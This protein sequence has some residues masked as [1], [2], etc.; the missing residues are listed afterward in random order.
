VVRATALPNWFPGG[1]ALPNFLLLAVMVSVV[2]P[3]AGLIGSYAVALT[4]AANRSRVVSDWQFSAQ[5]IEDR[6]GFVRLRIDPEGRLL[7]Y[8][9]VVDRVARRW[10]IGGARP[11][12]LPPRRVTAVGGLPVAHLVEEPVVIL[13][14][15]T[16][17]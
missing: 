3:I 17:S 4:L 14:T 5:A 12:H 1:S 7:M 16:A 9:V 8:P 2:A 15:P 6:K 11:S 10:R 13:R